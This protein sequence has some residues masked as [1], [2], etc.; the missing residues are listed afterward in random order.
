MISAQM[1]S[2]NENISLCRLSK[3]FGGCLLPISK[4]SDLLQARCNVLQG[5]S[6]NLSLAQA[7]IQ[8]A[9]YKIGSLETGENVKNFELAA[10]AAGRLHVMMRRYRSNFK[11]VCLTETECLLS[12]DD[13]NNLLTKLSHELDVRF[14]DFEQ[15]PVLLAF[16]LL[17]VRLWP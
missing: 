11:G 17:D 13:R 12:A 16:K 9:A 14:T 3:L 2:E 15:N 5:E 6:I 8:A 1:F 10:S 7:A 4:L